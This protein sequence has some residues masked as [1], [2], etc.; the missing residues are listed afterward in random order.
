MAT[1][2]EK[3]GQMIMIGLKGEELT[4]EEEQLLRNYSFGGFILFAHNLKEPKQIL[5]LCRSLWEIEKEHLPFIAI[6][7]EGGRVHRLP[8]PFTHFPAAAALGRTGN[9]DL[10]YRFGLATACELA[11]V[12]INL[13]FAPVLD[14]HSNPDNPVIGDRSLSSD[15][16]QVATLGW[17]VIEGLRDGGIIPCGKHFPGHG[18]T[19]K[20]SHLDLPVVEKDLTALRAVELPPFVRACQNQIESLMTA[21]VLYPSLDRDYPATL[22][23]SIIGRLLREEI[24]YQGVVFGDD[25]EMNAI[26][27]NFLLAEAVSRSVR[28]GVDVLMFCHDKTSAIRAFDFLYQKSEKDAKLEE[29]IEESHQRIKR[30][31]QRYLKSFTGVDEDLL[32]EHIG[33]TSHQKITEEIN[34]E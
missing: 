18:D 21:H 32:T 26:S 17:S 8:A 7:Q 11:A 31:K 15:P 30:L 27:K 29:R 34:E 28:A 12:G 33:I 23:Q 10:A 6:D 22:S 2:K 9:T 1:L 3:I 4:K 14:V 13:N 25:L 24:G 20:D 5:S 16:R 19:T